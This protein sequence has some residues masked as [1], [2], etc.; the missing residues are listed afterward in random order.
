MVVQRELSVAF[1]VF[2]PS[3]VMQWLALSPYSEKV[4]GTIP[5]LLHGVILRWQKCPAA[6]VL[7]LSLALSGHAVFLPQS[8]DTHIRLIGSSKLSVGVKVC[9]KLGEKKNWCPVQCVT[10]ASARGQLLLSLLS[11]FFRLQP[12]VSRWWW[13]SDTPT[14]EWGRWYCR[15][16][17]RVSTKI[18]FSF[19]NC[20]QLATD[21]EVKWVNWTK[22]VKQTH[23][24]LH[25]SNQ[26]LHRLHLIK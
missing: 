16:P 19:V 26:M 11:F 25:Q 13:R 15:F 22:W 9:A 1:L 3:I 4:L 8:K 14:L 6:G 18:N 20:V 24:K 2:C 17:F 21:T 23:A 5:V 12:Q 10:A 7:A